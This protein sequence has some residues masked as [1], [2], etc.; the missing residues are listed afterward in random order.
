MVECVLYNKFIKNSQKR[1]FFNDWLMYNWTGD[2][3]KLHVY[4]Y[5]FEIDNKNII[6]AQLEYKLGFD[7]VSNG[8]QSE[9]ISL[10]LSGIDEN[11]KDAWINIDIL[12]SLKELNKLSK[13]PTEIL[14]KYTITESFIKKPNENN[15]RF[16][17]F[18]IKNNLVD[19]IYR[20]LSSIYISKLEE[21][22]F[23]FK[24]SVPTEGLFTWFK[25]DFNNK[26]IKK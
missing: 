22:L 23:V 11:N 5:V 16:L 13:I 12:C 17:D 10:T 6:G 7:V 26:N 1:L 19:D 20:N 9:Y 14:Q 21:N 4:D 18:E 25:I 15:S 2:I 3:M 24:I 8:K